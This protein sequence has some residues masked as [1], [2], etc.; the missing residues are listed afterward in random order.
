MVGP[1]GGGGSRTLLVFRFFFLPL[2]NGEGLGCARQGAVC[3][4]AG[5]F[6]PPPL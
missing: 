4:F 5:F 6:R 3:F 2:S 1:G